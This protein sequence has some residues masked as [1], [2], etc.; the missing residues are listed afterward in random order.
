MAKRS[1]RAAAS[2]AAPA[3]PAAAAPA[4]STAGLPPP[5]RTDR[6]RW[7][8]AALDVIFAVTYFVVIT[9][10]A[11]TRFPL[12]RAHLY[13]LPFFALVMGGGTLIAGRVGW[14]IAVAGCGALLFFAVLLIVR[15]L[16]SITFLAGVYGSFGAAAT[17]F[18]VLAAALIVEAVALLP[19]FQL[20]YLMTRAGRRALGVLPPLPARAT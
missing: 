16:V 1:R 2:P 4:P 15:I 3:K 17:G 20:K 14:W 5:S 13:T 8:Y 10:L 19:L 9:Q 18:A 12:D 7:I 11:V 6:R